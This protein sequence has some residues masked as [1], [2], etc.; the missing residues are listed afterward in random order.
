MKKFFSM[1]LIFLIYSSILCSQNKLLFYCDYSVFKHADPKSVLELY[2]SVNQRDLKYKESKESFL[3]QV[4]VE[5]SIY[6]KVKEKYVFD[7]IFGLQSKVKDT[8]KANLNN[9]II[10]Q[11]N[12]SLFPGNYL[13]KLIGFDFNDTNKRDTVKFDLSAPSYEN[14]KTTFSDIQLSSTIVKSNDNAS[15]FYKNGLEVT[16]NPDVLFGMNLKTISYYF[17]IYSIKQEFHGNDNYLITTITDLSS[18]VLKR[19]CKLES[20]QSDAF[21]R[22]G[23]IDVDSLDRGVYNLKVKLLDSASGKF[24]EKEKKFFIY[25]TSKNISSNQ[26]DDK[27]YLISE[28]K[29]MSLDKLE[30][31]YNKTLYIRTTSEGDEFNSLKTVDEKRKYMYNFWRKRNNNPNSTYSDSKIEY[32]KRVFEA[33]NSFRQGFMEGWKTER[34]RIYIIYGKPSDV[35]R[36]PSETDTKAYEIWTYE[37][38]QGGAV[39]AFVEKDI[40][41]SYYYLVH[42]TIRGEFRDDDWKT[43]LKNKN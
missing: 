30:D 14:T 3:G 12:F 42:S 15:I 26:S 38:I 43:K 41:S 13:V 10:G 33:N 2:F 25:N 11:Q 29:E 34:G 36:H 35:E 17:E 37:N 28:Y 31:E 1:L 27:N 32:F 40:S 6:D 20:S 22:I 16:P 21:F 24:I 39:C 19:E 9:K 7:D 4:N 8:N 18:N 5:I 23:T